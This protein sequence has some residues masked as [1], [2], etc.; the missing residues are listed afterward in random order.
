MNAEGRKRLLGY[1]YTEHVFPNKRSPKTHVIPTSIAQEK[2]A[3]SILVI[4]FQTYAHSWNIMKFSTFEYPY[5]EELS[6]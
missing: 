6:S 1:L 4:V 5:L 2:A 3:E